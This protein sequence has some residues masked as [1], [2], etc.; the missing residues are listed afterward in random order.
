M[1]TKAKFVLSG[2]V[3]ATLVAIVLFL[4]VKGN[5]PAAPEPS[6]EPLPPPSAPLLTLQGGDLI[7]VPMGSA[8][9][10]PGFTATDGNSTDL[11]AS[12]TVSPIVDVNTPGIYQQVYSVTNKHGLSATAERTVYVCNPA[13]MPKNIQGTPLATGGIA[14]EQTGKVIHLTFD[15]GPGVHTP[16]LLNTLK[17]YNAK[18]TFFVVNTAYLDIISRTAAEGHTVGIHTYS[19]NYSQIYANDNTYL[20]DL[21][22]IQKEIQKHTGTKAMLMRFPGGSSNTVSAS[23][24]QGI[25]SRLTEMLP[26]LGYTYFDWNVDSQ[27]ATGTQTPQTIFENVVSGIG[28]REY[29]VVLQH[30]IHKYSVDA[31]EKILVW[32]ICNGYRFEALTA[33]SPTCHHPVFN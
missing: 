23:Y 17:K 22:A 18:A 15:D 11:S 30:D 4:C 14:I 25:M 6:T 26:K 5:A 20:A 33:D 32:G 19:H 3:A 1:N 31:V 7:V 27:D 9:E 13:M 21:E 12:V 16:R 29:S 8:Y 24:N 2:I 10:D 28:Q